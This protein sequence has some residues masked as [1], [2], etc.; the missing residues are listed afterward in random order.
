MNVNKLIGANPH[1]DTGCECILHIF[2]VLCTVFSSFPAIVSTSFECCVYLCILPYF[3][4]HS[5]FISLE[6]SRFEPTL[7]IC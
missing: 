2:K 5:L 6:E 4:F 7:S 1:I 3:V